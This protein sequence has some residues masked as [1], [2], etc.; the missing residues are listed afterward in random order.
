M[1]TK[2]VCDNGKFYRLVLARGPRGVWA[3]WPGGA[4][5]LEKVQH[6]SVSE[7]IDEGVRAPMTGRIVKVAVQK[8][9]RVEEN[10]LLV[11]MEAMKME[12]R[13]TSP[14]RAQIEEVCC[15]PGELV[16]LGVTVVS[17]KKLT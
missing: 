16:D 15:R 6:F 7:N 9:D 12:Y 1:I 17:L 5:Y 8:G 14:F 3:A 4:A 2:L 11:V 10:A 13:L